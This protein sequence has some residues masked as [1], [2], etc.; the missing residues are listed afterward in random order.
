VTT[1]Q[2]RSGIQR[3]PARDSGYQRETAG[4]KN[5]SKEIFDGGGLRRLRPRAAVGAGPDRSKFVRT[6]VTSTRSPPSVDG[7]AVSSSPLPDQEASPRARPG[8]GVGGFGSALR[9]TGFVSRRV[10]KCPERRRHTSNSVLACTFA[11]KP[12]LEVAGFEPAS[13]GASVGLLR[14]QPAEDCRGRHYCRRRCRP[15]SN[16]DVPCVQLA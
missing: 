6:P 1:S 16:E 11:T 7:R 4:P 13:F 9:D 14:A 5:F 12:L 10:H 2:V 8:A 3:V 15:V